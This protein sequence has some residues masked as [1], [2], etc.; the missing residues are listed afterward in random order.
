MT[1]FTLSI[2][3]EKTDETSLQ[4]LVLVRIIRLHQ[5]GKNIGNFGDEGGDLFA[6]RN[7]VLAHL[8][9][10][11]INQTRN[12]IKK[13]SQNIVGTYGNILI[14]TEIKHGVNSL[15]IKEGEELQEARDELGSEALFLL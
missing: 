5:L 15:I 7:Q 1:L 13:K 14:F 4:R 9:P 2:D 6:N 8:L 10:N 11:L 12:K 3:V